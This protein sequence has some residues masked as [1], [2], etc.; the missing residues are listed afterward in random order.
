MV[1]SKYL[2][3]S[4][5]CKLNGPFCDQKDQKQP[6]FPTGSLFKIWLL[7]FFMAAERKREKKAQP[8]LM[9]CLQVVFHS[10]GHSVFPQPMHGCA[11]IIHFYHFQLLF[12]SLTTNISHSATVFYWPPYSAKLIVRGTLDILSC[13]FLCS[14]RHEN[15]QQGFHYVLALVLKGEITSQP[16]RVVMHHE[17]FLL[18]CTFLHISI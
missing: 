3:H 1:H 5:A 12:P 16:V 2:S 4:F 13:F 6:P 17:Q 8:V 18:Y 11:R 15:T 14:G 10:K 9:L 7:H